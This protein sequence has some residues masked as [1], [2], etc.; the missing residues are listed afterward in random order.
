M[1][2][3]HSYTIIFLYSPVQSH[4]TVLTVPRIVYTNESL[5]RFVALYAVVT[6]YM[7]TSPHRL[8]CR[9]RFRYGTLR[10]RTFV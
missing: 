5:H 7:F 10:I 8:C 2:I 6:S 9:L 3:V 1:N 4:T